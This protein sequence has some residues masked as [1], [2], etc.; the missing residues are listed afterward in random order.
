M[1]I[2]ANGYEY[3]YSVAEDTGVSGNIVDLYFESYK[4]MINFGR[5]PC[6]CYILE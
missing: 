5:R 6:V 3:G 1:Y 2:V 4:G